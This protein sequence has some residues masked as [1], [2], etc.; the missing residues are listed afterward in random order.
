MQNEKIH[1]KI[2]MTLIDEKLGENYL[3]QFGHL[4]RRA[5]DALVKISEQIQ[6]E[7]KKKVK[8]RLKTTLVI[9]KK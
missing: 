5:I 6:V 2:R 3:K 7:K 8:G 1:L 9:E 4:K